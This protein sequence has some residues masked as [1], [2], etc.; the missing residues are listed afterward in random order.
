MWRKQYSREQII[1]NYYLF[2]TRRYI[3]DMNLGYRIPCA[4]LPQFVIL[5]WKGRKSIPAYKKILE[6]LGQDVVKCLEEIL[7][8]N[9][10][11]L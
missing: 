6:E 9:D 7:I 5:S 2:R 4:D 3:E 1:N 8:F 10:G 11:S